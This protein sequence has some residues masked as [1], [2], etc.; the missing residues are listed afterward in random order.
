[1]AIHGASAESIVTTVDVSANRVGLEVA[2]PA[3]R[4]L[5]G[6]GCSIDLDAPGFGPGRCV[7]TLL[8]RAGVIIWGTAGAEAP[9]YRTLV[10]PSFAGYLAAWLADATDGLADRPE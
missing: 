1:V 3:A 9:V 4:E 8:A 10:R 2:G 7:Q 6:F 5:L